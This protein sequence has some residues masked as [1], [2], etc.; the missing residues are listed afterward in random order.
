MITS[1]LRNKLL[2]I[3]IIIV[4]I[5]G[6][7]YGLTSSSSGSAAVLSSSGPDTSGDEAIISSLQSLQAI[8]LS[9][10]IFSDPAYKTLKDYTTAIVPVPAGRADPFAPISAAAQ[11]SVPA[12]A[13]SVQIFKP[14]R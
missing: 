12:P 7:W 5:G 1:I 14:S 9:G 3:V 6:A 13:N 10:T 11:S 8:S 2:L 4:V